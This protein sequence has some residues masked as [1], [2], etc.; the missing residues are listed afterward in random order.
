MTEARS[1]ILRR[2][3]T[4][5]ADAKPVTAPQPARQAPRTAEGTVDR[6]IACATESGATVRRV[7]A[8]AVA[9][10]IAAVLAA[11]RAG[12]VAVPADLP[13]GW[14]PDAVELAVDD[15]PLALDQL[16]RVDGVLNGCALAISA[17]GTVVFDGGVGQGRRLLTLVPDLHVCVVL[18]GQIVADVPDA[19]AAVTDPARPLTFV[20]GPSATS[21]IELA[22]VE[23]VHGPRRLEVL[24]AV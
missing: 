4:A 16:A 15:P 20:T 17:T 11:H 10:A 8:D 18:A 22:R 3:R 7:P 9:D 21:D 1:E 23:G 6:F 12:C 14:R 19:I 13:P 2:I 5:V 24:V